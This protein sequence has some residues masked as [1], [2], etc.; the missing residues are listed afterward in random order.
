MQPRRRRKSPKRALG[1][2]DLE[3]AKTA[4]SNSLSSPTGQRTYE[5]AIDEFVRWP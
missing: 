4:V 5:H 1:I 2:P 3:Q